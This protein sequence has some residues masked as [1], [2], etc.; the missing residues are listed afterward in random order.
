MPDANKPAPKGKR[1]KLGKARDVAFDRAR[2]TVQGLESNPVGVL[3]GGLAFGLIAG[4]LIPRS[5]QEKRALKP[6]GKRIAEGAVAAVAAAKATGKEQLSTS[7]LT[8]DAAK[9]SA[10]KIFDSALQAAKEKKPAGSKR[11]QPA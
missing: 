11:S 3:V 5:E 6:V 7:V 9:E 4:A 2:T 1:A 10:R 8:K